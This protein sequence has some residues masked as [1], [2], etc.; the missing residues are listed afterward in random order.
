MGD[1]KLGEVT[2]GDSQGEVL[3]PLQIGVAAAFAR[4]LGL[5]GQAVGN[6][7]H[8]RAEARVAARQLGGLWPS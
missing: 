5:T 8:K 6:H 7:L 2:P 1:V 4:L 3:V